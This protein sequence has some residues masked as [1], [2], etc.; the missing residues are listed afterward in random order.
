MC[1]GARVSCD[2]K[3]LLLYASQAHYLEGEPKEKP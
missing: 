3:V 2:F 1:V